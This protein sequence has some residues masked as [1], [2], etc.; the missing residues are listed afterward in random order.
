MAIQITPEDRDEIV[1]VVRDYVSDLFDAFGDGKITADEL[2][3]ATTRALAGAAALV[4]PDSVEVG[5]LPFLRQALSS[6]WEMLSDAFRDEERLTRRIQEAAAEG[7]TRK[8]ARL[9]EI[10][11]GLGA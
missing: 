10:L 3:E 2:R 8:A 6:G 5:V 4:I 9:Q 1:E 11:D 7:K